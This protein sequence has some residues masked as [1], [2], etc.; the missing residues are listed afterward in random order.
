LPKRC[1]KLLIRISMIFLVESNKIFELS[2][3]LHNRVKV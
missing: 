2:E 1:I 3:H